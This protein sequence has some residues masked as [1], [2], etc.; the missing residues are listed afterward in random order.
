VSRLIGWSTYITK[1]TFCNAFTPSKE[2]PEF[3][4]KKKLEKMSSLPLAEDRKE[5]RDF[6]FR[7]KKSRQCQKDTGLCRLWKNFKR[8]FLGRNFLVGMAVEPA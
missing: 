7:L 5:N 6:A 2:L 1:V 4:A 8:A 3:K